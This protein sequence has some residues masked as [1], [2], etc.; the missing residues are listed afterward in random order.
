MVDVDW[1]AGLLEEQ[2]VMLDLPRELKLGA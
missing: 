1:F 2:L